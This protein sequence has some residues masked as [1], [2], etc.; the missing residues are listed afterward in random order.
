MNM[1]KIVSGYTHQGGSTVAL[2]NLTNILNKYGY[3]TL[4]IGPHSWFADKCNS[5]LITNDLTFHPDDRLIFH[6]IQQRVRPNAKKVVLT[7]HEKHWFPLGK[8]NQYWDTAVFLHDQHRQYHAD[9]TGEYALI[10]NIRSNLNKSSCDSELKI[11]GIIGTIEVRKQTHVS[12]K[13]ALDDACDV[14][15]LYGSISDQSY[16]DQHVKS[17]ISDR[18]IIKG[19]TDDKQQIYDSV[20][21]VYHS[22]QAEVACLIKDECHQTG[23]EFFGNEETTHEVSSLTNEQIVNLWLCTLGIHA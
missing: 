19:F 13:R 15:Y 6:Y 20:N 21:R 7:C 10:P 23:V 3:E 14:V 9:Y 17:L 1:I 4:M 11:A 8:I 18:V 2:I 16:F 12:I 5:R 22:S